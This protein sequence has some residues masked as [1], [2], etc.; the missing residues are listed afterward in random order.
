[1]R[2]CTNAACPAQLKQRVHHFVS[3]GAMDIA[4]LG[5]KLAD[6]FVDL[7]MIGDV[8]DIYRLDWDQLKDLERLG[9]KSAENLRLAVERSKN[10]PLA[11][12]INALGIRHIGERSAGL[13]A[14]RYGSID[15]LAAAE[16]EEINAI[17]GIGAILAQSAFDFFHEPRN[18]AVIAK[19][20]ESGVRTADER[21]TGSGGNERPLAGKT[22]VL[23]GRLETMTRPQAEERLRRA[24]AGISGSVSKKTAYV[25]A[26][27]EPGSKADRARELGVPII[28]EDEL[29]ALLA[30]NAAPP[31]PN[32]A[33][34]SGATEA[35]PSEDDPSADRARGQERLA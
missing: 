15:A 13:L 6:R 32:G 23:T 27:E 8:A 25:V 3:R 30:G 26:G 21:S 28:G 1:M 16:M 7:G 11:R 33:H 19:L 10:R 12:L 20:K 18:L 22:F 2:Y 17:G 29:V 9:E 4:G 14:D 35:P 5:D 34:D 24:G 31:A